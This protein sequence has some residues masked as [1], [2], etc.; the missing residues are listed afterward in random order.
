MGG[1]LLLYIK[2]DVPV[3]IYMFKFNNRNTRARCEICSK[4]T[5]RQQSD[6]N[7]IFHNLF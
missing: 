7:G 2:V 6:A 3:G 4:L 5:I 1:W